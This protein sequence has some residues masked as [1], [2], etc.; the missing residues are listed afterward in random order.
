MRKFVTS[1][2]ICLE[3]DYKFVYRIAKIDFIEWEDGHF[4]YSFYPYYNVIDILPDSLFQGIPGLDLSLR[5]ACYERE[6]LIPVFIS[7]RTPGENREDVWQLMEESGMQALNR[8]E[9]L[10]RTNKRY[11]GDRFL[12]VSADEEEF[13]TERVGSIFDLVNRSDLI[14]KKLLKIICYGDYLESKEIVINDT[15]RLDYYRLLM[16]LY[17]DDY[18]RKRTAKIAGI[19]E[20]KR[21]NAYRGRAKI[22]IDPLLFQ[23][24][25]DEYLNREITADEAARKLN[26]S[27][28]TFLRRLP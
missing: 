19:K 2:I 15:N 8:L 4:K 26:I 13:V 12:V 28:A 17:I 11:S 5:K 22:V 25:V 27:R 24:T 6:N 16:A 21:R 14:I 7:E 9:W 23:R 18:K 3:D 10:I 20:A 1:G